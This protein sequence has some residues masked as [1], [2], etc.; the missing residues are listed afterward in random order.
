MSN[1]RGECDFI[2]GCPKFNGVAEQFKQFGTDRVTAMNE[3][4]MH[5]DHAAAGQLP[6]NAHQCRCEKFYLVTINVAA[7]TDMLERY[8]ES[9]AA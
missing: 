9:I 2:D 6:A 1:W 4:Y 3:L 8:S 7:D 5:R